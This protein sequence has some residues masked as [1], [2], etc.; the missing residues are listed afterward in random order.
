MNWDLFFIVIFYGLLLLIFFLYR[1]KFEVQGKIFVLYKTKLGLKLMDKFA[2]KFP[3]LLTILGYIG[4]F[5]GFIGMIFIFYV[6]VKGALNLLI[7]PVAQPVLAPVLPG[8]K[9]AGLP[10]LSFWYWI[11]SI[12][13]VAAV[14]EFSHGLLARVNKIKLKSSGFAF[15][16]PL[17]AAFVEPDEK[18]IEK[19]KKIKQLSIFAAGPFSNILLAMVFL[20]ISIFIISPVISAVIEPAGVQIV[21]LEDNQPA[22]LAGI[23]QGEIIKEINNIPINSIEEFTPIVENIKPDEE[24]TI[25]TNISTYTLLTKENPENKSKPL[26]GITISQ[27]SIIKKNISENYKHSLLTFLW[28]S[29][30]IFWL[31]LINFGVGLFNLL[32]LGPVDGG[33]MF[34]TGISYFVK[35]KKRTHKIWTSIS[36][37]C[38]FLIFINLLPYIIKLILFILKAFLIF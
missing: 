15:L 3:T 25:K 20:L 17:L 18:Q 6:L 34:K 5:I 23:K 37:L 1:S 4:V 14:H 35:N 8:I 36:F 9:I 10:T 38:L 21:S 12:F 11:I 19:K 30:L 27:Y 28:I 13:I 29:K 7:S 31:Y 32:P 33:R 26:I 2:K 22:S 16:G 24:I